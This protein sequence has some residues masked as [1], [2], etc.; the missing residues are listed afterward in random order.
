MKT[1]KRSPMSKWKRLC[2]EDRAAALVE[3]AV[4]LPLLCLMLL[5]AVELA[6]ASYTAIEVT[7]AANA[8]AQYGASS[9]A[10]AQDWT[11]KSSVYSGGVVNAAT[12][13]AANLGGSN[14]ISVTSIGLSCYC[15]GA[16]TPKN[17]SDNTTCA[18]A[19]FGMIEKIEVHT[20][21][22][23]TPLFNYFSYGSIKGPSSYTLKGQAIQTVGNQ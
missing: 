18:S 7:N 5:G 8:A 2:A 21:A 15:T 13:D 22:T 11:F 4:T 1:E 20:Q 10:A 14:A 19:N 6:R 3:L 23:Y 12:S 16:A 9:H 17:C